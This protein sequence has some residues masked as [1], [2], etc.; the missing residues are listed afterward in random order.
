MYPL[1]EGFNGDCV[2]LVHFLNR[3]NK[4]YILASNK[5]AEKFD[6]FLKEEHPALLK[7]IKASKTE[8]E[9]NNNMK[10]LY[11]KYEESVC[12]NLT[13]GE[14]V[15]KA[16]ENVFMEIGSIKAEQKAKEMPLVIPMISLKKIDSVSMELLS[17]KKQYKN[18]VTMVHEMKNMIA[19]GLKVSGED[20]RA[21]VK[22]A[23]EKYIAELKNSREKYMGL[24]LDYNEM[25]FENVCIGKINE[26]R[27]AKTNSQGMEA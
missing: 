26:Q 7:T 19:S 12:K 18:S 4:R 8:K 25:M 9:F 1:E 22:Q 15:S 6:K 23:C 14:S 16:V 11:S 5:D 20:M 27:R 24:A 3:L 17:A 21:Q 10:K 13:E 2:E